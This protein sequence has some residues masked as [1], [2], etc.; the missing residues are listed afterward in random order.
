MPPKKISSTRSTRANPTGKEVSHTKPLTLIPLQPLRKTTRKKVGDNTLHVVTPSKK[1][2]IEVET[3]EE[4]EDDDEF[5][6]PVK[7]AKK[8]T[9]IPKGTR[10]VAGVPKLVPPPPPTKKA[11]VV[12][13]TK[14]VLTAVAKKVLFKPKKIIAVMNVKSGAATIF[15]TPKQATNFL[16][17]MNSLGGAEHLKT[18]IFENEEHFVNTSDGYKKQMDECT[19][20]STPTAGIPLAASVPVSR[21]KQANPLSTAISKEYARLNKPAAASNKL[22]THLQQKLSGMNGTSLKLLLFP[23]TLCITDNEKYQVFAID[24]VENKSDG[25]VWT[26][27]PD[28]WS[29][30]FQMDEELTEEDG[31]HTIEPFFY[32]LQATCPRSVPKGPNIRKQLHTKNGKT[33][34]CQLLWGMI[35]CTPD[36]P[37]IP[38][39]NYN[40]NL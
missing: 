34:D 31:G 22:A 13:K 28:A 3:V 30:V 35:K 2:P 38:K 14:I 39:Q 16:T 21:N 18:F 12:R 33:V 32:S 7:K 36:T 27:K 29:K 19:P 26:H 37:L 10:K 11:P 8:I 24:L 25:T 9:A 6:Q 17:Q 23:E 40:L 1:S 5:I 20:N 15:K 4:N